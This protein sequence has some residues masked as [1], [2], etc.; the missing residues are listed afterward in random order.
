MQTLLIQG[1]S[2]P[3]LIIQDVKEVFLPSQLLYVF[4]KIRHCRNRLHFL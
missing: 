3:D 1:F 4:S 2:G